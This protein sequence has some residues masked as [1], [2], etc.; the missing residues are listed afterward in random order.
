MP[1][2]N[3]RARN[4]RYTETFLHNAG[5]RQVSQPSKRWALSVCACRHTHCTDRDSVFVHTVE[6]VGF[7][8]ARVYG[9]GWVSA[10]HARSILGLAPAK[11]ESDAFTSYTANAHKHA[12]AHAFG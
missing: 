2:A 8:R 9:R 7:D 6:V 4:L 1:D 11:E 12:P 5:G 10:T 3:L